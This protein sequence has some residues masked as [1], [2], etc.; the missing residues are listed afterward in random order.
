MKT[1]YIFIF[2]IFLSFSLNCFSNDSEEPIVVNC[3]STC[4]VQ[5]DSSI[6]S[7]LL[8]INKNVSIISQKASPK[9]EDSSSIS[10]DVLVT[11][12]ITILIF[13]L[14]GLF[15]FLYDEW[16]KRKKVIDFRDTIFS[17]IRLNQNQIDSNVLNLN[18]LID[19]ISNG[20]DIQPQAF[21]YS[22]TVGFEKLNTIEFEKYIANFV[23]NSKNTTKPDL[24]RDEI[25]NLI[26]SINYLARSED[27]VMTQYK[28]YND[29]SYKLF[30]ECNSLYTRLVQHYED[31]MKAKEVDNPLYKELKV[32]LDNYV[33]ELNKDENKEKSAT[34][35]IT[36]LVTPIENEISK[37]EEIDVELRRIIT[38]F[39]I[40]QR[41]WNSYK[42]NFPLLFS[43]YKDN[44][45]NTY[46]KLKNSMSYFQ[47]KTK[48]KCF[49]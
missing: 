12:F 27:L 13:L 25:N 9:D 34:V 6:Y 5:I 36:Y 44:I 10:K 40:I 30:D 8:D 17:G 41:Q 48:P 11:I 1:K 14:G 24:S 49:P 45:I 18:T 43:D 46:N 7:T 28:R 26:N 22:P 20:E 35:L 31:K 38:S 39:K 16:K 33:E 47:D 21:K 42:I 3:N 4:V 23:L 37:Y 15:S 19:N 2:F 29:M 32:I